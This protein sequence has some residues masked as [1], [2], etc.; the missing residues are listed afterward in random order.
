MIKGMG[1]LQYEEVL[2][3]L[4]FDPGEGGAERANSTKSEGE[5]GPCAHQML[6]DWN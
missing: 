4:G 5:C 3:R 1:Q 2:G 6:C